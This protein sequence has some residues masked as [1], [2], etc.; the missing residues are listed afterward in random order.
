MLFSRKFL[1]FLSLYLNYFIFFI[2]YVNKKKEMNNFSQ[3]ETPRR[4]SIFEKF[5][6]K[7]IN[8]NNVNEKIKKKEI[9]NFFN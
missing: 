9:Y 8:S 5:H 7:N 1:T 2:F 4:Q 6:F 3:E